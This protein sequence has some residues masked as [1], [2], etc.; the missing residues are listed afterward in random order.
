MRLEARESA[1]LALTLLAPPAAIAAALLLC[2]LLIIWAGK[3]VGLAYTTLFTSAAGSLFALAETFTRATPL[4]LTGLAAA[5]A[6]RAKLWNIGGEGQLYAGALAAT[7]LGSGLIELPPFAMIP[8]LVIAGALAGAALMIGPAILKLRFGVDEVVTT[9]L[10][11]FIVLL[12]VSL[13]LEGPLK[14]PMSMG[15]PQAA[16]IIQEGE[17]PKLVERQRLHA[18]LLIALAA[19]VIVW[20]VQTR[21]VW[22]FEMRA[23]GANIKAATFLGL[24]VNMALVRVALL[25]GGLAGI[26]GVSEVAGLKGYL[27]LDMSP[28]YGY[29]GI[30]VAMLAQLHPLGVVLAALFV[31]GIFVGAD[32][33]S[34]AVEVPTY[35]ADV[36]V[37]AS[38]LCMLVA[39]LTLR[40][41]VRWG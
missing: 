9:L 35:I 31:A 16:P 41:R 22:G 11:N 20:I 24:P 8:L 6:F 14:D 17:L 23:I 39:M 33:M 28:G 18:G 37:A 36:I 40:Y 4:I 19:S 13:L 29:A 21:T 34:R 10:L 30:V 27:T 2:S 26:A 38:L 7:V 15:W 3:P 1:P 5:V 25:S 32:G 12:F